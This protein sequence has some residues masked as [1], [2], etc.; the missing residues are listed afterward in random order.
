MYLP[1]RVLALV[2]RSTVPPSLP[3]PQATSDVLEGLQSRLLVFVLCTWAGI[4]TLFTGFYLYIDGGMVPP[5]TSVLTVIACCLILVQQRMGVRR[6]L[7][8]SQFLGVAIAC[9]SVL[10]VVFGGIE[11]PTLAWL[12]PIPIFGLVLDRPRTAFFATA[13]V[14]LSIVGVAVLSY[15]GLTLPL[16]IPSPLVEIMIS[17]ELIELVVVLLAVGML[18][19][20]IRSR[21]NTHLVT[22]N[23]SLQDEVNGHNE[24]RERLQ[25]THRDLVDAARVA[26]AA[27]L[28]TGVLHNLGN[29]LTAVNVSTS[30]TE[31]RVAGLRLDRVERLT[32]A[33]PGP[34][35]ETVRQYIQGVHADLVRSQA[36]MRAELDSLR[37]GVDHAIATVTAQQR[38]ARGSGVLEP[39]ELQDLLADALLLST[40]RHAS[41]TRVK[42]DCIHV[43]RLV[44][45][46]HRLVQIVMNLV[47]NAHDALR[48]I[49]RPGRISVV[50]RLD[51]DMLQLSVTDNGEGIASA[52]LD[53][54]FAHGF[55]TKADGH[56][57]GLHACALAA[58]EVGGS[59]TVTSS[60][61]GHGATFVLRLPVERAR[62]EAITALGA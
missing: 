11:S 60:G 48:S 18:S 40:H 9:V 17:I 23:A 10:S 15:L 14:A 26:G 45:D 6:T 30:L 50:G 46:R 49:D 36:A 3:S 37:T 41:S 57:F 58:S 32:Q 54:V 19:E 47:G 25:K 20:R 8:V 2:R 35:H 5:T 28:A 13:G 1:N 27:E 51:D 52:D 62:D 31:S 38:H 53:R 33:F 29:A 61:R 59:L 22:T 39:I 43:P 12:A 4:G 7:C 55:T 42:I 56:G 44:L 24:T 34:E 16:G 21:I